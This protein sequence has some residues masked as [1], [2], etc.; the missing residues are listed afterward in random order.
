MLS[1]RSYFRGASI[2]GLPRFFL[3]WVVTKEPSWLVFRFILNF[4]EPEL[5][6]PCWAELFCSNR[7]I[8]VF[9]PVIN[10]LDTSDS[11]SIC[12]SSW[13][14]SFSSSVGSSIDFIKKSTI[15][16]LGLSLFSSKHAV[17]RF[18]SNSCMLCNSTYFLKSLIV[19]SKIWKF[20]E[21]FAFF[22]K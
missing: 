14:I 4:T 15:N 2:F 10:T 9:I 12:R 3:E 18:D 6:R 1:C 7:Q 8:W 11:F 16:L 19:S 5:I 17:N 20:K 21:I 13:F 22:V